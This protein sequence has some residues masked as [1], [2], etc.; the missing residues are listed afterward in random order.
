LQTGTLSILLVFTGWTIAS[1]RFAINGDRAASKAVIAFIF[2]YSPA[3][4]MA[5]NALTYRTPFLRFHP[6]KFPDGNYCTAYLV[7]LFPFH[8]RAK[9][10][11]IFQVFSR[12]AGAFNQF[13]NPIGIANSGWR[14]YIR[15]EPLTPCLP[16]NKVDE[17]EYS[18]V[19]W[20]AFEVAF[21]YFMFP[22]TSGRTLEELAFRKSSF[23][24]SVKEADSIISIRGRP[25]KG[26]Q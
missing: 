17:I 9:G 8:V 14:Y 19:V 3:Y 2:I 18:Y 23:S 25:K 20:V 24:M 26:A 5:C 15:Q 12:L 13:V 10:I 11:A 21:V 4:N 16:R 1:A 22:E 6:N 7:E